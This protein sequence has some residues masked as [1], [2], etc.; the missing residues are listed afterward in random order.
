MN[1]RVYPTSCALGKLEHL[2]NNST[3]L[4]NFVPNSGPG[5]FRHGILA[6]GECD[7]NSDSGRSGVHSTWRRLADDRRTWQMWSTVDD[8]CRLLT[9]LSVQRCVQRDGRLSVSTV[10]WAPS[11]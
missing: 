7:I 5:K 6:V 4:W 11:E 10:G 2:Q 1:H 9:A 8:N 3:S